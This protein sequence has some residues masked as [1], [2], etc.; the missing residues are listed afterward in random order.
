MP[1]VRTVLGD[2]SP[3]ELG[4]VLPHEHVF[5][6]WLGSEVDALGSYDKDELLTK[7][8]KELVTAKEAHGLTCFVDVTTP[9]SGRNMEL[10]TEASRRSGVHIVSS[11]GF[12]TESM[13]IPYYWHARPLDA[14]E[15]FFT[16]EITEGVQDT[17]FKCG[18][19]KL[20]TGPELL[21]AGPPPA[22]GDDLVPYALGPT[23]VEE[24]GF[25]AAARVQKK[26]GVAITTHTDGY[27]WS[28]CNIGTRQLDVLLDEG[29]DPSKCIIG[30]ADGTSNIRYLAEIMD[31]GA[32][33]GLDMF[34]YSLGKLGN[35]ARLG[36]ITALVSMGYAS[37]MLLS[38][39]IVLH[40]M[41]RPGTKEDP[42]M[43]QGENICRLFEEIVPALLKSGVSEDAIHQMTVEN[44]RRI[45]AF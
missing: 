42:S 31:R 5:F 41:R 7:V 11:T 24:K 27:D 14:I 13:G 23:K 45:L 4:I 32:N 18:I 20:A 1:I 36:T 10:M 37:Q 25:R 17:D 43:Y 29:A 19:I 40:E 44:P 38:H 8:V 22:W 33:L 15:D 2:I 16:R 28:I 39:D 12:Y 9:D 6:Y 3:D 26:L 21:I 35:S 34:A 30:H